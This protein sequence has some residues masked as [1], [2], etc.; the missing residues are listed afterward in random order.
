MLTRRKSVST[1][2]RSVIWARAAGRCQFPACGQDLT[3]DLVA[4][5]EDRNFGFIA[6]I[7]A[8]TPKGPRG[9]PV[10]SSLLCDDP[11]NLMLLCA[12]HH[13][14]IDVDAEADYPE[15]R[16]LKMKADNERRISIVGSIDEERASHVIRYAANIGNHESP[17]AYEHVASAMLPDRYPAEGRQ[18]IDLE[19]A[20]C[21]FADDEAA[22]WAFQR[23]NLVRQFNLKV[24]ER[25]QSRDI[26]HV[27]V[28][29]LAPQPLLIELGRQLGD[30]L[31]ADVHQLHREPKGWRW[32]EDVPIAFQTI[33]PQIAD[34]TL[35]I[36]L[37]LGLSASVTNDRVKA[38]LGEK[39]VIWRLDAAAPHNDVMRRRD[40]LAEFRRQVRRLFDAIKAGHGEGA[41][42]N[43]FP[44]LP[45]STAI[46]VG[47]IWMPKAD[48]PLRLFDQNRR[49]GGFVHA[50]DIGS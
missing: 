15:A 11:T 40:D 23:E 22:Y 16:L 49:V 12:K 27:S 24:R 26:R 48:L 47:R 29:G 5:A 45:V 20:G 19:L 8:E 6:H 3:R 9:D 43:L 38:V 18:T 46:E 36:A 7:V 50:F 21:A 37:V 35:P 42:I 44:A 17:L 31:P 25:L 34:P 33:E 10:R 14:W 41:M 32:A 4:G 30:I 28:F 2:S 1:R 39:T 13:K